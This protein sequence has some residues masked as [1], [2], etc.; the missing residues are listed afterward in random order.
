[1]NNY[2]LFLGIVPRGTQLAYYKT[3]TQVTIIKEVLQ[4]LNTIT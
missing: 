3:F 1:M 2:Y 4:L